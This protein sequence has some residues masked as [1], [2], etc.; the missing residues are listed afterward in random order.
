[1]QRKGFIIALLLII[2]QVSSWAHGSWE[3]HADDMYEVLGLE[4]NEKLTDW[5]R[6]V[7]M[8]VIKI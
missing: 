8:S 7:T 1:M 3:Q 5:M 4:R 6:F 2:S